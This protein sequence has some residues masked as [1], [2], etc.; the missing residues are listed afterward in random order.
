MAKPINTIKILKS[1]YDLVLGFLFFIA[2]RY[3]FTWLLWY[4]RGVPPVSDNAYFYLSSAHN[5]FHLQN[6]EQFRLALFSSLLRSLSIFTSG[7]LESAFKLNFYIGPII[8]FAAL[9]FFLSKLETSKNIRLLILIILSLYSGSGAYHGFYWVVPSFYQLALFFVILGFLVSRQR[10]NPIMI[11]VTSLLFIFVHPT[12]VFV[13]PIFVVY[14]AALFILKKADNNLKNNF[15]N[16]IVSL[17]ASFIAYFAI[18]RFFPAAG[19]PESFQTSFGLIRSFFS[20]QLN[21]ISWPIIWQEY[22]SIFFFS[23]VSA[24]AYV[25]MFCFVAVAKQTKIIILFF[26]AALLVLAGA[27]I[28]YGARTLEFLWPLTFI[29]IGYAFVG[30]FRFLEKLSSFAKYLTVVPLIFLIFLATIFNLISIKTLNATKDYSW[31]RSCPSKLIG[32]KTFFTNLE[33]LY[34][35]NLYGLSQGDEVFL[36]DDR[37]PELFKDGTFFVQTIDTPKFTS[38]LSTLEESLAQKITRRQEP[39]KVEFPTNSWTQKPVDSQLLNSKLNTNNL[40]VEK[41]YD[42]GKYIVYTIQKI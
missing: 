14:F 26:S 33:S 10:I 22:F 2:Y 12:S 23:P 28:P 4:G 36:S 24:I 42:C 35:F 38:T 39:I 15:K 13:S 11:F 25:L 41:A 3:F 1:N 16:L 40:V 27:F 29:L 8:M 30:L 9:A 7:N 5:F 37:L 32:N 6:F 21:S 17:F 19:S 18:G 31:D 20:G 34:A